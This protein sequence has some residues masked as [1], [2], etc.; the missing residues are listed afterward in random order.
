MSEISKLDLNSQN[1]ADDKKAKLKEL[2]PEIFTEGDKI[3]FEKLRL[4]L[5]EDVDSND[6]RF[7][8]HWAGKKECFKVIQEPSIGTL[9]PAEGESIDWENT[10]NLFIEGDNL[11][12]LKLLQKSYY[13]KVKMI[14]IDPPYNT[15]EE[16]I[17]PDK[18]QE[19]LD[20]YLAYSNQIDDEGYK[21]STNTET[22][23]RYHSNWLNMMY[24]RL[25]LARN[26]MS[27][28][29]AIFI[30][31]DDNELDNLR[32]ICNEIFGEE[33]FIANFVW[34]RR[35]TRENRRLISVSHDYV[36]LYVKDSSILEET[37]NLL[38]MSDEAIGRYKNPD[39][40]PRGVWTSVPAIAQAG[41]ATKSQ[42][43]EL[44]TP[45]GRKVSPPSG[46]C[47][48][49]TEKRMTEEISN[50]N[51]WFGKD[52][53]GVP[54]IKKFLTQGRQGLTPVTLL[55]AKNNDTNDI[56]KRQLNELFDGISVFDAPKPVKLMKKLAL[57]GTY[58]DE[59]CIALDFF[60]GS[61]SF[62]NA[63]LELNK[64]DGGKRKVC[65]VQLPEPCKEDSEP[66]NKLGLDTIADIG[67]ER[68]RRVIQKIK[69]EKQSLQKQLKSKENDLTELQAEKAKT[70]KLF[71]NGKGKD[72]QELENEIEELK[73]KIANIENTDL[74]FKVFK[75]DKSNFKVW[76]GSVDS[77]IAKQIEMA[78]DHV[79]PESSDEDILYEI[80]LKAG[81]ELTLPIEKLTLGGKAVYAVEGNALL[82]CLEKELN[83]ELIRAIAERHPARVVCLDAGFKENDQLK[84]NAVQIMKSHDVHDFKTV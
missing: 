28:D 38:P 62:A 24:P 42:F 72:L 65:M 12:V 58:T 56:G 5:G 19:N 39:K 78:I 81:F 55:T 52:G 47:W 60:T 70:P 80:L 50:N 71:E 29:G 68:I 33:N 63:I 11:E 8:L 76:N 43:Y 32:K 79:N 69:D 40:D 74:G 26:L 20:T 46:S 66:K 14:Y 9:K 54:R 51:L 10:E 36:L 18:Y 61:A 6:E 41:H 44:I 75:L 4:T 3:D 31:I 25:F 21:F 73:T 48:R 84:T 30:S 15:G 77:D 64:E 27:Q 83:E 49:Y 17:Y 1:I 13:G 7:G 22:E 16:F 59:E 2:F 82:I 37:I 23:G 34:Q 45:S 53:T 35:I 67:K 57:I